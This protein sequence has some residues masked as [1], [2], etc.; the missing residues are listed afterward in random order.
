MLNIKLISV[1]FMQSQRGRTV[2]LYQQYTF[3]LKGSTASRTRWRCVGHTKHGCTA[4]VITD[5]FNNFIRTY[6]FHPH[7][8]PNLNKITKRRRKRKTKVFSDVK[9]ETND[10]RNQ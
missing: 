7:S 6:G 10:D 8:P 5:N 4:A 1:T 3:N 2:L 9:T